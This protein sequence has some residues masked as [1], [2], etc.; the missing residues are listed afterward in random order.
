M[1]FEKKLTAEDI[2]KKSVTLEKTPSAT[3]ADGI[4]YLYTLRGD[5]TIQNTYE[6]AATAAADKFTFS[7]TALTFPTSL[8]EGD[9]IHVPYEYQADGSEGNGA[10]GVTHTAKD[11]PKAGKFVMEV[12][13]H[14]VCNVSKNYYAFVILPNAKLET[15]VDLSFTSD[16][17]HPFSIKCNQDYCDYDKKLYSIIIPE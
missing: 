8:K 3:G 11:F 9:I 14:D 4:P 16:G 13:G 7:G 5:S 2:T 6:Y 17:K 15:A 1:W 10:I 12:L